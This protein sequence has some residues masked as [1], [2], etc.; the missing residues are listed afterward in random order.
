MSTVIQHLSKDESLSRTMSA[1]QF[2]FDVL[3]GLSDSPKH[4][5]SKYFYDQEGSRLFTKI[6]ELEEYYPTK[7]EAEILQTHKGSIAHQIGERGVNLVDLGAGDGQ[8]TMILLRYF[9]EQNIDV[10]FVPIDISES[11][12]Q[13]LLDKVSSEFPDMACEGLVSEY[14]RGIHW[15][16]TQNDHRVNLVLFLG[17]NIG[18]FDKAKARAHLRQLWTVLKSED[19]A[20]IGFD[21]KK[22]IDILLNAYNDQEG[23][24]A[25]F[26]LNLL[27]RINRELGGHFALDRFRHFATY[28]VF[29][30]AM[31]SYL[32][33]LEEQDVM[34]EALENTFHFR[35]WEP[36][37]TEYSYKYLKSD[38]RDLAVKTG[39]K[40]EAEYFDTKQQFVDALWRVKKTPTVNG[41]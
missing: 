27:Q 36:I 10:R 16:N 34:V 38:I 37:H 26:N 17:S 8:K 13:G 3:A 40:V 14:F 5:S 21:L 30:G 15:L 24:T 25:Q 31:E 2:S 35:A 22:D 28:N 33:S 32:V 20:L 6:T 39:F 29:S 23:V 11:A 1:Q 12:I 7:L 41:S 18:N 19:L 4:L 9:R